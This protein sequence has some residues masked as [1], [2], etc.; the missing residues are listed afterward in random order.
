MIRIGPA[1][2]D[3]EDWKGRVYPKPEPAG[4]DPLGFLAGLFRTIEIN[5]TFYRPNAPAAADGWI[6]RVALAPDFRFTAKAWQRL[7]HEP[8]WSAAD[9]EAS[10]AGLKPLAEA[11]RL[12]AILLQF[13]W[14]FRDD[15]SARDRLRR[16]TDALR[17]T[18]PLVVEI[19]HVSWIQPKAVAFLKSLGAGFANIDQPY[20]RSSAT[21]TRF[22]FGPVGY[23]RLHGRNAEAWFRKGAGRDERYDYLYSLDELGP[24]AEA[25][26]R[27]GAEAESLYVVTNN[28]FQG[29]AV[30]NAIQLEKLVNGIEIPMPEGLR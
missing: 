14:S 11:G 18:A 13:P 30:I 27:M 28:H 21:G 19:R 25:A 2:W 26:R 7:T 12:G 10:V 3:Y 24:W 16:L 23:I 5:S 9:A 8:Q 17:G 15:D 1:G 22:C 6:R 4:F 20:A 29:K